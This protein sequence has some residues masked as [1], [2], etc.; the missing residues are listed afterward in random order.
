MISL[1][2]RLY[3]R[4]QQCACHFESSCSQCQLDLLALK[5]TPEVFSNMAEIERNFR[6]DMRRIEDVS[7]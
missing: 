5:L 7:K 3:S 1:A 2:L 4:M 6:G